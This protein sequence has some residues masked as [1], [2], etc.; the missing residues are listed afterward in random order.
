MLTNNLAKFIGSERTQPVGVQFESISC[1]ALSFGKSAASKIDSCVSLSFIQVL[2]I[3]DVL[4]ASVVG[5]FNPPGDRLL[6]QRSGLRRSQRLSPGSLLGQRCGPR[7]P[8]VLK[9]RT[10]PC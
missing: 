4:A 1:V 8:D 10:S 3:N 9:P 5:P 7:Q 2:K 6:R